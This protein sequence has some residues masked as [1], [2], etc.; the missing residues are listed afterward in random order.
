[1]PDRSVWVAVA[2]VVVSAVLLGPGSHEAVAQPASA[3]V[4]DVG[5]DVRFVADDGDTVR[6]AESARYHGVVELRATDGRIISDVTVEDYVAGI[7]EM[8]SRWPLEALKSQAVAARTYAWWVLERDTYDGY[9]ICASTACQVYRGADVVLDDGER[10]ARAVTETAGEV[11]LDDAGAP[12]LARYF[13][14]SGGRTYANEEVF[15][16]TGA[17]DHLVAVE[18]PDD[19]VSPFH[20]WTVRFDRD[21][22]DGLLARGDT[23]QAAVP[24]ADV[25]RQGPV[26]RHDADL[27]VTGRDGTEVLVDA[28]ALRDFLNRFAPELDA[29]RY[30]PRRADGI[31][32]LPTTVPSTRFDV[33]VDADEV[34]IAGQGWGH[35]V[36]LGQYGARGRADRG[37]S[38]EAILAT[39]YNGLEPRRTDELPARI[40]V[41]LDRPVIA[42]DDTVALRGDGP[43]RVEAADGVVV[44]RALGTWMASR[45]PDGWTLQAPEG[46]DADLVV[47][48]TRRTEAFGARYAVE[49]DVNKPALLELQVEDTAG[50]AVTRRRIGAVDAGTHA[51]TWDGSDTDGSPVADGTYEVVLIAED[52]AGARSGSSTSITVEGSRTETRAASDSPQNGL[53]STPV[54]VVLA[55][56]GLLVALA[57]L[58][59]IRKEPS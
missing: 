22:F 7:A 5:G 35:G 43:V 40:R 12:V 13:S 58:L 56:G 26:T 41:G 24:V 32:R 51:A 33:D 30:P 25:E 6:I 2:S 19:A 49:V 42:V 34:V 55:V 54:L 20:R 53:A 39:Y 44:E 10:W 18:D 14:T 50:Q 11:L 46:H 47:S 21:E 29:A 8:P 15:P 31:A 48:A 16:S 59:L 37:E 57:L 4:I 38:Y 27:L 9:D 36:G 17:M 1:M 23:L 28:L 3:T 52:A 45:K